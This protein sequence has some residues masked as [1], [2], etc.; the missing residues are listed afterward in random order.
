MRRT[1]RAPACRSQRGLGGSNPWL[2]TNASHVSYPT[3]HTQ[4]EAIRLLQASREAG[5]RWTTQS[6]PPGKVP[7]Q[8]R[9]V[10]TPTFARRTLTV[11][12]AAPITIP[13][14]APTTRSTGADVGCSHYLPRPPH[15][16]RQTGPRASLSHLVRTSWPFEC[17]AAGPSS[18]E[19]AASKSPLDCTSR[20]VHIWC[21]SYGSRTGR[22]GHRW[23]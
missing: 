12:A 7:C 10:T 21:T 19:L 8:V 5:V 14:V 15:S 2:F 16:A 18:W 3:A 1:R 9:R 22:T 23:S 11:A 6:L 4:E 17:D 13:P 20:L